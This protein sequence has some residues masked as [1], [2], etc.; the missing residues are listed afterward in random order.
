MIISVNSTV[1][2]NNLSHANQA[3]AFLKSINV[4]N[5][6]KVISF[7][8]K[9]DVFHSNQQ[10]TAVGRYAGKDFIVRQDSACRLN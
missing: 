10:I 2:A 3:Y 6:A 1:I 4:S 7:A 5:S 9:E 8:K